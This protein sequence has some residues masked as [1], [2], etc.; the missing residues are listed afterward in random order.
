MLCYV[1]LCMVINLQDREYR[2]NLKTRQCTTTSITRPFRPFGVPPFAKF[3][4]EAEVGA[5]GVPGENLIEQTFDGEFE[6]GG[7]LST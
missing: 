2:L 7:K 1:M 6:D 3:L 4:F 5:A